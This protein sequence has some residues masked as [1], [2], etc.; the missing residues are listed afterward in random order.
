LYGRMCAAQIANAL[1][2]AQEMV[3][4]W[5]QAAGFMSIKQL[6]PFNIK[7]YLNRSVA[8][9]RFFEFDW[10]VARPVTLMAKQ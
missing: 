7:C 9:R 6:L 8:S 2:I 1:R 4:N 3:K 10:R 5:H